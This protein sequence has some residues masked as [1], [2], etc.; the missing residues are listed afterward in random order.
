MRE[1]KSARSSLI[2][3]EASSC[4]VLTKLP[5]RRRCGNRAPPLAASGRLF[6]DISRMRETRSSIVM[7]SGSKPDKGARRFQTSSASF[8]RQAARTSA[9]VPQRIPQD[10]GRFPDSV[11]AVAKAAAPR[12]QTAGL[13]SQ[14]GRYCASAFP[15]TPLVSRARSLNPFTGKLFIFI[16]TFPSIVKVPQSFLRQRAPRPRPAS[17][18]PSPSRRSRGSTGRQCFV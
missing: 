11:A 4:P 15:V 14:A 10:A 2:P 7:K 18:L 3:A 6:S 5:N 13:T 8:H 17:P 12:F 1:R 9:P 16:C